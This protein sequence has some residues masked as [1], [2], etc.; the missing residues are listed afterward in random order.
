MLSGCRENRKY[1]PF[2]I[3]RTG[4]NGRYL[5]SEYLQP[6]HVLAWKFIRSTTLRNKQLIKLRR[7]RERSERERERERETERERERQKE[8]ERERVSERERVEQR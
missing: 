6:E 5:N 1:V 8:R 7:I 3:T 2:R 4:G